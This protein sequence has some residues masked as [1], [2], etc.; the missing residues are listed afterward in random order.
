M[1]NSETKDLV[2]SLINILSFERTTIS[3]AAVLIGREFL[4]M[5]DVFGARKSEIDGILPKALMTLEEQ[6]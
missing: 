5:R 1:Q 2:R 6:T 3:Y 4:I